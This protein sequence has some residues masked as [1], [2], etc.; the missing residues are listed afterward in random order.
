[1]RS[2]NQKTAAKLYHVDFGG[3]N[4]LF[5]TQTEH[6]HYLELELH[7]PHAGIRADFFNENIDFIKE[8]LANNLSYLAENI[9][10]NLKTVHQK[11][12]EMPEHERQEIISNNIVRQ[13][14]KEV[15]DSDCILYC[16]MYWG[17]TLVDSVCKKL[18]AYLK[19][20][21][22][23]H[24][25][26]SEL[27]YPTIYKEL[28]YRYGSCEGIHYYPPNV[29]PNYWFR[30]FESDE[31]NKSVSL[32]K[33]NCYYH[34]N[35]LP[36]SHA[37]TVG[38]EEFIKPETSRIPFFIGTQFGTTPKIT[39][40]LKNDLEGQNIA[41]L[42]KSQLSGFE[43]VLKIC[44]VKD[45]A[46]VV[47]D[48]YLNT[49]EGTIR[50]HTIQ[51][52]T[53]SAS[54]FSSD[55]IIY[56][57]IHEGQNYFVTKKDVPDA[58]GFIITMLRPF[59]EMQWNYPGNEILSENE[60]QQIMPE[61]IKY[62]NQLYNIVNSN[63]QNWK[64]DFDRFNLLNRERSPEFNMNFYVEMIF[65]DIGNN[66]AVFPDALCGNWTKSFL[67]TVLKEILET[68]GFKYGSESSHLLGFEYMMREG[69]KTVIDVT[70][71]SDEER[72]AVFSKL[73]DQEKINLYAAMKEG[74]GSQFDRL[75]A[76]WIN[77][78]D[79]Y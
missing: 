50:T 34:S 9:V 17:K 5:T 32:K 79:S 13:K 46:F 59:R 63:T 64:R 43:S 1:M 22:E 53:D 42:Y 65:A 58:G 72:R 28:F 8:G 61:L 49:Q 56:R 48:E 51:E 11:F 54:F 47:L 12:R 31:K 60:K 36:E 71:Y 69:N 68:G 35:S 23:R 7:F 62:L 77:N 41:M 3:K 39:P 10:A 14:L 33:L 29:R 18:L 25:K 74:Y 27:E 16:P 30:K 70:P 75:V 24:L 52:E 21:D 26:Y 19:E 78:S 57:Y 73:T 15:L 67:K 37:D 6:R 44:K 2:S 76:L 45:G 38:Y 4:I 20:K 55:E 66:P 40:Q